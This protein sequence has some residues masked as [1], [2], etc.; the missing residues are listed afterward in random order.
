[1]IIYITLYKLTVF[2]AVFS[3]CRAMQALE[4]VL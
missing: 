4:S 1:M 2:R 3:Q